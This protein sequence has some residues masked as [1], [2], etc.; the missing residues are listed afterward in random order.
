MGVSLSEKVLVCS[1]KLSLWRAVITDKNVT[2]ETNDRYQAIQSAGTYRKRLMHEQLKDVNTAFRDVGQFHKEHTLPWSVGK[3]EGILLVDHYQKYR[4]GLAEKIQTALDKVEDFIQSYTDHVYQAEQDLGEMFNSSEYPQAS[5]IRDYFKIESNAY[6]VPDPKDWRIALSDEEVEELRAKFEANLQ[7]K[8][9][10]SMEN[11][12]QRLYEPIKKMA[13]TLS[14]EDK[15][16]KKSLV[17][18]IIDVIALLPALNITNDPKLESL[19]K[20]IE[21]RLCSHSPEILR[22]NNHA[23]Q[24]TATAARE[25]ADKMSVFVAPIDDIDTEKW[26][27]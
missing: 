19:R 12:W 25:I 16:F 26:A 17:E 11:L 15:I 22:T 6:P 27:A 13:E 5:E 20:E 9:S 1:L 3:S 2:K 10:S 21:Q 4:D 23:R 14:Q 7:A 24:D 18:N 8:L